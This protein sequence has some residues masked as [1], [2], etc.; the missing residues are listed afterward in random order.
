MNSHKRNQNIEFCIILT[1]VL[2]L[3]FLA[4]NAFRWCCDDIFIT[5]RYAEQFLAGNGFVYNV[6]ERVEGYSNFLW[7]VIITFLQRLGLDPVNVSTGLG[8][9][10]FLGT[11]AIFSLISRKLS[12]GRF[13][14]IITLTSLALIAN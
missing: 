3:G 8:I 10:S 13:L 14:L 11:L 5:L 6:G 2:V 4:S 9:G 7:L 1:V 12:S